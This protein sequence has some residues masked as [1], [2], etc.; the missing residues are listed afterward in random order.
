MLKISAI[1]CAVLGVVTAVSGYIFI[2][3]YDI[4]G[5]S[6]NVIEASLMQIAHLRYL[7]AS[8]FGLAATVFI[9]AHHLV[10][11]LQSQKSEKHQ[12]Q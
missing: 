2:S 4:S 10:M 12:T 7:V 6:T 8:V 1:I 11:A 5:Y 3:R 9:S